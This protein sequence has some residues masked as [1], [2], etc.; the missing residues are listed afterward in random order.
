MLDFGTISLLSS[1][2]LQVVNIGRINSNNLKKVNDKLARRLLEE[3]IRFL[4][5]N[6]RLFNNKRKILIGIYYSN[7]HASDVSILKGIDSYLYAKLN[8]YQVEGRL[9]QRL[10]KMSFYDGFTNQ[11]YSSFKVSQFQ[12]ITSI[13][14]SI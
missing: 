7:Q 2:R 9:L 6:T 12:E 5:S 8:E 13:W 14:K 10:K 1:Y 11:K 4:T 3:R